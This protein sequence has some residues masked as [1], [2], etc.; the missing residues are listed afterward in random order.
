MN[1]TLKN[2]LLIPMNFL[3]KINPKTELKL[4][5]YLKQGH[6][7]NLDNP[8]TYNEK[9]NWMKLYYRNE[10]MPLCADKY[11]VRKYVEDSGCGK[12]LTKLLWEGFKPEKIPFDDLP[13]K[14]VIKVT[15]GSGN[16]IICNNKNKLD[17][18]EIIER[19][20]GWLKEKYLPCYGEWFYGLVK[21]RIII[22]EFLTQDGHNPPEDY[23][24]YYFNNYNGRNDVAL[25]AVHSGR[26]NGSAYSKNMYDKEW[27]FMEDFKFGVKNNPLNIIEKP[28]QYNE[29]IEYAKKL[30]RPFP[31]TRVDFYIVKGKV[32]FGE[33]TFMTGAGFMNIMPFSY[34]KKLGEWIDLVTGGDHN[35]D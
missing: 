8:I 9:L 29:M 33:I 25:T 5:F 13:E 21:P 6:K 18:T 1:K 7:L 3:Y 14:F 26:F 16:N 4:M 28:Y 31:H 19:L 23:K 11:T 32:Y 24:L 15:H 30:S 34:N 22:E 35:G 27:R 20:N 10:L 17:K 2:I 12:I